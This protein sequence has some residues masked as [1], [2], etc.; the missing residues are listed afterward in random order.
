MSS[1]RAAPTASDPG[2]PLEALVLSPHLDDAALSCGG[3]IH[4]LASEGRR[5]LVV[6]VFT[7]DPPGEGWFSDLARDLHGRWQLGNDAVAVR[8]GEDHQALDILGADLRH[9]GFLDAL[10]RRDDDDGEGN[11]DPLYPTLESL[12]ALPHRDDR[13]LVHRLA[14]A[15]T[16]LPATRRVVAPLA[17]GNHIDHQLVRD[18]ARHAFGQR[19]EYFSDFPYCRSPI[20][21]LKGLRATFGRPAWRWRR[22]RERLGRSDIDRKLDAIRCYR[23]QL[24]TAFPDDAILERQVRRASWWGESLWRRR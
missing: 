17:V 10:Y 20:V 9:L 23:S 21:L 7:A 14:R 24:A 19:L 6:T 11:G 15:F 12:F 13:V 2:P 18:A 3:W 22:R 4:R 8:R 5:V 1:E 16:A